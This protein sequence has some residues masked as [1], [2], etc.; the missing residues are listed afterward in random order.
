MP[1]FE[2]DSLYYKCHRRSLGVPLVEPLVNRMVAFRATGVMLTSTFLPD[3]LCFPGFE[4][5]VVC[6]HCILI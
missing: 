6:I 1:V 2:S 5:A 3:L 4:D